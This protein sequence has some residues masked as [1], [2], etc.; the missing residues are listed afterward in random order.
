MY[1]I[2]FFSLLTFIISQLVLSILF[3]LDDHFVSGFE[4]VLTVSIG[5]ILTLYLEWLTKKDE[6]DSN[7]PR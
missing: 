1:K 4:S 7:Q 3:Y 2:R 5:L 6:N